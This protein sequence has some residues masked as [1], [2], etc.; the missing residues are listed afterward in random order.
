MNDSMNFGNIYRAFF[1]YLHEMHG[2]DSIQ[3][4]ELFLE[5]IQLNKKNSRGLKSSASLIKEITGEKKK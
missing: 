5:M 4:T 3:A 1:Q 2:M